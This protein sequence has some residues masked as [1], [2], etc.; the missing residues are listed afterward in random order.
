MITSTENSEVT[1]SES[2]T[3]KK[4]SNK[5]LKALFVISTILLFASLASRVYPSD[6]SCEQKLTSISSPGSEITETSRVY[7]RDFGGYMFAI[8]TNNTDWFYSPLL[9]KADFNID[10]LSDVTSAKDA[11][12]TMYVRGINTSQ[13]PRFLI[14]SNLQNTSNVIAYCLKK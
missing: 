3:K 14:A 1:T 2:K 10:T 7:V 5:I 11:N 8:K 6:Y 4:N 13:M 9:Y 12:G